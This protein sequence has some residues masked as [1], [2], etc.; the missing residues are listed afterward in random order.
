[1]I[2]TALTLAVTASSFNFSASEEVK[3]AA[4]I[5]FAMLFARDRSLAD[6]S[7]VIRTASAVGGVDRIDRLG[8]WGR[9]GRWGR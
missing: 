1:M 9:S 6:T 5:A 8:R 3:E 4:S 7:N 2:V